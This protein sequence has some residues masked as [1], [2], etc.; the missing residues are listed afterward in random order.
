MMEHQ[1]AGRQACLGDAVL[2]S[3]AV[4]PEAV[5]REG[6]GWNWGEGGEGRGKG[7]RGAKGGE[8][9]RGQR[10]GGERIGWDRL[11]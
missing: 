4:K 9:G 5:G 8:G 7:G 11:G 3:W 10:E 6:G 1:A 2:P